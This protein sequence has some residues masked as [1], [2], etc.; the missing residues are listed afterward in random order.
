[1]EITAASEFSAKKN[2]SKLSKS[3]Q[4]KKIFYSN[5]PVE[6][7]I[8]KLTRKKLCG[9]VKKMLNGQ[10]IRVLCDDWGLVDETCRDI[11]LGLLEKRNKVEAADQLIDYFKDTHTSKE[12][13][14]FRN[15]LREEAGDGGRN[16]QLLKL[17]KSIEEAVYSASPED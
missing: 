14:I 15:F 3:K 17:A 10:R 8:K 2:L 1:M 6:F 11:I 16:P 13:L 5:V 7:V 4:N 12:L 9:A